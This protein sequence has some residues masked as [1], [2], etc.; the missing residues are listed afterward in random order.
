MP[1]LQRR[2][3]NRKNASKILGLNLIVFKHTFLRRTIAKSCYPGPSMSS[4]NAICPRPSESRDDGV[5]LQRVRQ[6][7]AS[8]PRTSEAEGTERTAPMS[9]L[10]GE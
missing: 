2:E 4:S 9:A 6:I 7:R 3:R 5:V 1:E 8:Q 10:P